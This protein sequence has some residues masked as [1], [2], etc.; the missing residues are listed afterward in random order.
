MKY[1]RMVIISVILMETATVWCEEPERLPRWL[2]IYNKLEASKVKS[3]K[4]S[5]S[6]IGLIVDDLHDKEI[7][8]TSCS[9]E[10]SLN[11]KKLNLEFNDSTVLEI[12]A[13]ASDAAGGELKIRNQGIFIEERKS[14]SRKVL[15]FRIENSDIGRF[16]E[17]SFG[18][19][20]RGKYV[21]ND[22]WVDSESNFNISVAE[23]EVEGVRAFFRVLDL[24]EVL[25][26]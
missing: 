13:A 7:L 23:S 18:S 5:D 21:E 8:A 3:L 11:E 6:N 15:K 14:D 24:K 20:S 16:L 10:T 19:R 17:L 12:L 26:Q 1:M 4:Y 22:A 25:P 2:R 9:L